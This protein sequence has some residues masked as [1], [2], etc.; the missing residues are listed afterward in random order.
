ML[1]WEM[2]RSVAESN[3]LGQGEARQSVTE[4]GSCGRGK[5]RLTHLTGHARCKNCEK[6]KHL[7]YDT[8]A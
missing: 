7:H 5:A 3:I 6:M 2:G 1:W 4:A 8:S